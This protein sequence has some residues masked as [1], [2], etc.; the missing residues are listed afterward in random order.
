MTEFRGRMETGSCTIR[1]RK[2]F[3][4]KMPD[5]LWNRETFK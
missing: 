4:I 3:F 1:G 5:T 2:G